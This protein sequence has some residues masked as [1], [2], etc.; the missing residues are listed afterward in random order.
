MVEAEVQ[1]N[2]FFYAT[3]AAVTVVAYV[4]YKRL[5]DNEN[6]EKYGVKHGNLSV[7]YIT[8]LRDGFGQLLKEH[9]DTVGLKNMQMML[10]TKDLQILR[11]VFVKDFSNFIDRPRGPATL[12]HVERS[13]IF[14]KGQDWRRVRHIVTPAY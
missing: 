9:G 11:E 14:L 2:A 6:W 4:V 8:R 3:I 1:S 7:T 10:V 13:L 5:V 12:S